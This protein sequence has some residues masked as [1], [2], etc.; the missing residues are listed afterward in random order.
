MSYGSN[1]AVEEAED[2]YRENCAQR[3]AQIAAERVACGDASREDAIKQAAEYILNER[4][5]ES[6]PT[7]VIAA[8]NTFPHS[9]KKC[10]PKQVTAIANELLEDARDAASNL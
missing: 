8:E 3:I 9:S 10:P 1:E 6:D 4:A 7:G 5:A 2:E